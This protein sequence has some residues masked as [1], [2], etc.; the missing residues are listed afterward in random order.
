MHARCSALLEPYREIDQ[1]EARKLLEAQ[2]G[3]DACRLSFYRKASDGSS[4]DLGDDG[5]WDC[6]RLEGP[7]FV[8]HYRGTPHVHVWVNVSDDPTVKLNAKG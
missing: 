6:W 7:S 8:W 5:E 3:L 1:Q 2:G 4:I